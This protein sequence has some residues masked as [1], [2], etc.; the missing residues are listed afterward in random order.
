MGGLAAVLTALTPTAG[1]AGQADSASQTPPPLR[2]V[3]QGFAD[4]STLSTSLRTF[5]V[6]LRTPAGFTD[7]YQLPDQA[8]QPGRYVRRSG[9]ISAVFPHS[10]Y[11]RREDHL[12]ALVPAGTVY[13]IGDMPG[14]GRTSGSAPSASMLS[15]AQPTGLDARA[16]ST[17]VY[18]QIDTRPSAQ[19]SSPPPSQPASTHETPP[20]TPDR[21]S[22]AGILT[23]ESYRS[24]RIAQI[25]S[26]AAAN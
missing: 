1:G 13:Y 23:S 2:R 25:L 4:R 9:A 20:Q 10:T 11:I 12:Q 14:G 16:A 18:T 15:S 17:A 22:A 8:G 5:G 24:S 7:L 26:D 3:D 6:D 21:P 19:P